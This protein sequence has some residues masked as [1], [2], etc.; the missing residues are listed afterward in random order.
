MAI[1][2]IVAALTVGA[3]HWK[4]SGA[5]A[6]RRLTCLGNRISL[7]PFQVAFGLGNANL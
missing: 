4:V 6:R 5:D 2:T 3:F 1:P 7:Q